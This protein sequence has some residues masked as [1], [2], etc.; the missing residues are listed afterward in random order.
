MT[1]PPALPNSGAALLV[2]TSFADD[3]AWTSLVE[4]VRT[5][6]PG[7][8][9]LAVVEI[10]DQPAYRDL[11]ADRLRALLPEGE[12]VSFFFVADEAALTEPERPLLVVP[13][14]R[15]ES[16]FLDEPPREQ[17][18]VAVTHLWALENNLSLA[19]MDWPDF[20]NRAEDGVFRGF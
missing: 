12:Y 8:G 17:F 15:P 3:G 7:D 14:P 9:F 1:S 4:Q 13:V 18:R 20:A 6:S 11:P 10:V 5:P 19:N 2:R 16:P